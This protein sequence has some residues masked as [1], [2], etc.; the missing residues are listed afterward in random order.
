MGRITQIRKPDPAA[1]D[2][3]CGFGMIPKPHEDLARQR[4]Q[5]FGFGSIGRKF[6]RLAT[7]RG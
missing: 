4:V 7:V 3:R 2:E 5:R 6:A 1:E